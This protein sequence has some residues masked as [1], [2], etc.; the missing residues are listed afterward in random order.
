MGASSTGVLRLKLKLINDRQSADMARLLETL[1][2]VP[3][4]TPGFSIIKI[5]STTHGETGG[6]A[7]TMSSKIT[8]CRDIDLRCEVDPP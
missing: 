7:V 4:A 2:K 5:A 8:E 6:D 3:Q 1:G